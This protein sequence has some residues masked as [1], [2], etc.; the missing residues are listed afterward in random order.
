MAYT[1]D[2]SVV[3]PCHQCAQTI[4]AAVS[5]AINQTLAP[6]EIIL[7][8]NGSIDET[9]R[10]LQSWHNRYPNV[11]K[12]EVLASTGASAARNKGVELAC[13]EYIAF[14]DADDVWHPQKLELQLDAMVH[15]NAVIS[16]HS[17]QPIKG[18]SFDHSIIEGKAF[19]FIRHSVSDMLISNRTST[20]SIMLKKSYFVPFDVRLQR[21]EDWKCWVEIMAVVDTNILFLP[22]TLAAG[23]KPSLGHGGLS[24]DVSQMHVDMLRAIHFLVESKHI[25]YLQGIVA[26][27]IEYAKYPLRLIKLKLLKSNK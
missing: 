27:L 24:A 17:Y 9:L 10:I 22:L 5:S 11:I 7:V 26:I 8:E 1:H 18:E 14:L 4:D 16:A 21:C 25:S 23:S 13:G 20:P 3:I 12:L 6:L 19:K 2:I 15:D